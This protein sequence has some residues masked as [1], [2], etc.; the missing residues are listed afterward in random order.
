MINGSESDSCVSYCSDSDSSDSDSSD[1][2]INDNDSSDS[3]IS[4]N[5]SSDID[6][7]DSDKSDIDF[8]S[9]PFGHISTPQ[10]QTLVCTMHTRELDGVAPLIADPPAMKLH[11]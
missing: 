2:D 4:I 3:D 6:S 9:S 10:E 8:N 11:Q 1:R 5:D 7:S